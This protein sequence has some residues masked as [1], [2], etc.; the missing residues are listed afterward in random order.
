MKVEVSHHDEQIARRAAVALV[1]LCDELAK[2]DDQDLCRL[3]LTSGVVIADFY[4]TDG[5]HGQVAVGVRALAAALV[6]GRETL[7]KYADQLVR[8]GRRQQDEERRRRLRGL[9]LVLNEPIWR[10]ITEGRWTR[11]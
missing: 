11:N 2:R 3:S 6:G 7:R 4:A 9:S 8:W 10:P 5:A 1:P